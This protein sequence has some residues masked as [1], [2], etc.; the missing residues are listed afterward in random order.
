MRLSPFLIFDTETAGLPKFR[1]RPASDV[2]NW[3]RLVQI[4]WETYDQHGKQTRAQSQI[5]KPEGFVI[6]GDAIR[7]HGIGNEKAK[8]VGRDLRG[9]LEE[10]R[11]RI[12]EA[13]VIV[14]HNMEFDENVVLAEYHRLGIE[15][16]FRRKTRICTMRQTAEFCGIPGRNGYKW[17]TLI[18]LHAKLFGENCAEMHDAGADVAICSKCFFALKRRGIVG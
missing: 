3:P 18:E 2:D 1:N 7:I 15:N 17:P 16:D 12:Q 11:T 13:S 10:F 4:A 5:I 9:V 8:S 14:S 6:P